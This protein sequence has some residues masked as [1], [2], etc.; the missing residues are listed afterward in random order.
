MCVY[1]RVG[2]SSLEPVQ[3]AALLRAGWMCLTSAP[4]SPL[5]HYQQGGADHSS[6]RHRHLCDDE[7]VYLTPGTVEGNMST[8]VS[9]FSTSQYLEVSND[10]LFFN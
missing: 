9:T 1:G 10:F 8:F 7:E 5:D 3:W 2:S 6:P 4:A